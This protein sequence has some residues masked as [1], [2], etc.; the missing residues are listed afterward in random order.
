LPTMAKAHTDI[1]CNP[2]LKDGTAG[3]AE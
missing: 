1:R 2:E 3:I